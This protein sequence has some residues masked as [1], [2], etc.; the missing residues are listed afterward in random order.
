MPPR[1]T[2]KVAALVADRVPFV[3]ATVVRVERPAAV[4]AGDDALVLPD[5]S[6]EGFVGGQCTEASLREAA[7]DALATNEPVLLRVVPGA[8]QHEA[9]AGTRVVANPCLSGGT[10]EI[11]LEPRLPSPLVHV[12]GTGPIAA[13]LA[14]LARRLGW[15]VGDGE[16]VASGALAVVVA[17]LGR[18]EEKLVRSALDAGVGF[19]GVVASHR[20]AEALVDALGLAPGEAARVHAPV[21]LPIGAVTAE[22]IALSVL[23]AIVRA[24][25]LEGL[26]APAS[27]RPGAPL[28]AVDPLCGMTVVVAPDTPRLEV[29]EQLTYFCGTG[30]RDRFAAHGAAG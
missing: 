30:C 17:T 19:V 29:G 27:A 25:R 26:A 13:T 6:I 2:A 28:R 10:L 16:A 22:E 5:G 21:G 3:H 15:A 12:A 11:F 14:D 24:R 8:A 23:A 4:R 7:L 1:M 18:D 20:R 9:P